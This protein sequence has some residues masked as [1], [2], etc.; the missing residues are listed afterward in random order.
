MNT[1]HCASSLSLRLSPPI[2]LSLS[3]FLAGDCYFTWISLY[4]PPPLSLSAS[5]YPS[6]HPPKIH[7]PNTYP[8]PSN[9]RQTRP[10]KY[11]TS[12]LPP[13]IYVSINRSIQ[14]THT[15]AHLKPAH[16]STQPNYTPSTYPSIHSS[17]QSSIHA[18]KPQP[19]ISQYI[20]KWALHC[21]RNKCNVTPILVAAGL[22]LF[23]MH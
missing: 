8:S 5:I 10:Q 2:S 19:H 13:K 1:V 17:I 12:T 6:I 11:H 23:F 16:S 9:T 20:E 22:P 18:P 21:K 15:S 7:P 4:P 14:T 3:L